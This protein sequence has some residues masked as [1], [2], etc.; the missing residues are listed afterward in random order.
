METTIKVTPDYIRQVILEERQLLD[1]HNRYRTMLLREGN[2]L[3]ELG[4]DREMINESIIS[5]IKNL[6]SEFIKSFKYDITLSLLS[7]MGLS[8]E[9]FLAQAIGNVV[10]EADILD[11]KKY[12]RDESGC[13][14][15]TG[16]IVRALAET[17]LEPLVD[18]L[19]KGLGVDPQGRLYI[20]LREWVVTSL[21]HDGDLGRWVRDTITDWVC[22][23]DVTDMVDTMKG[24][25]KGKPDVAAD[26]AADAVQMDLFR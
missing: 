24:M 21:A 1:E 23:V 13:T 7:A 11:F 12:F 10:E 16:L 2:R 5:L 3:R 14:E 18:G 19:A 25:F 20:T 4:Y 26:V 9:G 17:G 22:G 15:L 6:G 8:K